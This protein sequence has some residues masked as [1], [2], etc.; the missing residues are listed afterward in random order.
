MSEQLQSEIEFA[1]QL[2]EQAQGQS[3][4]S[5]SGFRFHEKVRAIWPLLLAELEAVAQ[6]RA[7]NDPADAINLAAKENREHTELLKRD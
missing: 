6:L 7:A 4:D 1:Q 3:W 5:Y 2:Y